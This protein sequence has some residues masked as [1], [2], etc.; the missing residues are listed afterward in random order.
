MTTIPREAQ[1][2]LK[3]LKKTL[4]GQELEKVL[5]DIPRNSPL[6]YIV[7]IV[8]DSQDQSVID[9][10]VFKTAHQSWAEELKKAW[11]KARP[12]DRIEVIWGKRE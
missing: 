1:V 5:K 10:Y 8:L 9:F 3:A 7:T 4:K 11:S 12:K 6:S 2:Q